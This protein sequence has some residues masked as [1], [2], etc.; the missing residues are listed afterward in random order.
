MI[1][2]LTG[3]MGSGKTTVAGIFGA[4]GVPVYEADAASKK[5][6]DTDPALQQELTGLLGN[7]ILNG[8][9]IDR[10]LMAQKIFGDEALLQKVNRII[11]PAVAGDFKRWH[12]AQKSTYVIR[13]AAILFESGSYRD[14]DKVIVVAAPREMRLNRMIDH[15]GMSR[16]E[17]EQRMSR[18]WPQSQK[19]AR[20]DYVI[21]N[22]HTQSLIKQV[23]RIHEDII[24]TA[25]PRS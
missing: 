13:E 4:L 24:R 2:G 8:N 18:Q 9:R 1:I 19:L 16:K 5:L 22:D 10:S 15:R 20:A 12:A 6:L 7:E 3:G 21:H 11:H 25:N 14:C 17:A 23:L